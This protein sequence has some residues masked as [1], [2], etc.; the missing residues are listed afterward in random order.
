M[1][2]PKQMARLGEFYLEEAVLDV[3]SAAGQKQEKGVK[4]AEIGRRAGIF[5][6]NATPAFGNAIV[7]GIL[8]K[9]FKQGRI[10][11][12]EDSRKWALTDEEKEARL[13]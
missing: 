10:V 5:G 11:R 7:S 9:L 6:E 8:A 4:A 2:H 3:L 13:E 12:C 1:I